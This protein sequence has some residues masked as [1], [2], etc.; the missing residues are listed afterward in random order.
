MAG[1]NIKRQK[2]ARKNIEKLFEDA[3]NTWVIHYSCESFY[4]RTDGRSP[5]ITSI[6]CRNLETSQTVSFSIHQAA[7]LAGVSLDAI[8]A[9]YDDLEKRMLDRYF[10][11]IGGHRGV[12]YIHWNM[13]DINYG[14][15]A[16]EHRYSVLG[17]K[18]FVIGDDRK[19]DLARL[20]IDIYGVSYI[21]HP[22]LDSLLKLNKIE[23]KDFMTGAEEADA[24][25]AHNYVGLHQST[26]R[27]VDVI[28]N[29]AGRAR[30]NH[31]RTNTS[32][33][34]LNGGYLRA[35][36]DWFAENTLFKALLTIA[37][38]ISLMVGLLSLL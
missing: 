27:K 11:H 31:L 34:N 20:L 3:E 8:T 33:W 23:P 17:G 2:E 13:R 14:F 4:D 26:L 18:P 19:F 32:W 10:E 7:E 6:A 28:A 37:G 22:R 21:G 30:D 24:F 36:V 29:L 16:I 38:L 1:P 25:E 12:R 15:A 9:Q 35:V 5:R